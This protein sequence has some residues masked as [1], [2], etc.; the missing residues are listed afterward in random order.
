MG[1]GKKRL[2]YREGTWFA[3]PLRTNGFA[4][5][6]VARFAGDGRTFGYFF[7]PKRKSIPTVKAVGN[8]TFEQA[9]WIGRFG[10]LGL[11]NGSWPILG[12]TGQWDRAAWP[13]PA[14]VRTDDDDDE[15]SAAYIT[16]FSDSLDPVS[17]KRCD[18]K[19]A[20]KYPEDALSGCGAVEIR[21]TDLLDG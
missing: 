6:V 12:E 9:I 15:S 19:L 8:L 20:K 21:L 16:V 1:K 3:V 7:G 10:D 5:G 13:L 2:P 4:V 14:F 18:P 17:C 11:L